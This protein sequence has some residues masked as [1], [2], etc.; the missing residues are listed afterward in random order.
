MRLPSRILCL[1]ALGLLLLVPAA[2]RAQTPAPAPAVEGK[3]DL[4]KQ[5][6]PA[7]SRAEEA[8]PSVSAETEFVR[9]SRMNESETR[10]GSVPG[11]SSCASNVSS[12]LNRISKGLLPPGL[13]TAIKVWPS[14]S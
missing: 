4:L 9:T 10:G 7:V 3:K 8:P 6:T 12:A 1:A 14:W 2:A 11:C 5:R 13:N